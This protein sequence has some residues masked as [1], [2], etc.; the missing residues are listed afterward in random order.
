MWFMLG[1]LIVGF[2]LIVVSQALDSG[3]GN[4]VVAVLKVGGII[5][6]VVFAFMAVIAI[7]SY[8]GSLET[9][10][11]MENFYER[12]GRLLADAVEWY[13]DAI[14]VRNS[15]GATETV[16][17]SWEYTD[18]V[19]EYNENLKWHRNYQSHWFMG[20]FVASV[21]DSLGFLT[22]DSPI[23]SRPVGSPAADSLSQ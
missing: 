12:N 4:V 6:E 10:A 23:L 9:V 16:R 14:T 15:N 7:I 13:P 22:I 18:Q 8:S 11:Q 20:I 3:F 17:L 5:M 21:P 19:L 1:L 2:A